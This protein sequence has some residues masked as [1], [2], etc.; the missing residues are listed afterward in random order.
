MSFD[1]H[2]RPPSAIDSAA[3]PIWR[4]QCDGNRAL[5]TSY[6]NPHPHVGNFHPA[7]REPYVL[8][9]IEQLYF[10]NAAESARR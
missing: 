9:N 6:G 4:R 8:W 1:S 2:G 7:V 10:K 5:F 3:Y